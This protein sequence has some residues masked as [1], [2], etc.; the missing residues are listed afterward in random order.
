MEEQSL[1]VKTR[2]HQHWSVRRREGSFLSHGQPAGRKDWSTCL[3]CFPRTGERLV[4]SHAAR[5]ARDTELAQLLEAN[6]IAMRRPSCLTA[7]L[8]Q[9]VLL[10]ALL[11]LEALALN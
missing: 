2:E 11:L 5:R 9:S 8:N 1:S 6:D 4:Q 10:L 3:A 7:L